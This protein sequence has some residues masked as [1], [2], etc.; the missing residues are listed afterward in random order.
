MLITD[1]L[2]TK[3]EF[4][5]HFT[6]N[7]RLTLGGLL[8]GSL[9]LLCVSQSQY[10]AKML[11]VH[12]YISLD[13]WDFKRVIC[14]MQLFALSEIFLGNPIQSNSKFCHPFKIN[15]FFSSKTSNWANFFMCRAVPRTQI[16]SKCSISRS[17][18]AGTIQE[19]CFY[20][21]L[22][23]ILT[24]IGDFLTILNFSKIDFVSNLTL[25]WIFYKIIIVQ[26]PI[27]S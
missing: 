5:I 16:S 27:L 19:L 4:F 13:F 18:H 14:K 6:S 12:C 17:L 11:L 1:R 22:F 7:L 3:G 8:L 24:P 2:T 23:W 20:F 25:P 15:L 26:R 9:I 10:R 21:I